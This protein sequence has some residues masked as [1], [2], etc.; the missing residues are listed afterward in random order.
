[1]NDKRSTKLTPCGELSEGLAS[2]ALVV[3]W[4][5]DLAKLTM[6][7]PDIQTRSVDQY[8]DLDDW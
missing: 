6:L 5:F 2:E 8:V 1:M 7:K 4:V 3:N